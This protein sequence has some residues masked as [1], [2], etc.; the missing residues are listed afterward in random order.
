MGG[1]ELLDVLN[2]PNTGQM[3]NLPLGAVVEG[4]VLI[5][6]DRIDP[7]TYG[8]VPAPLQAMLAP[9]AMRQE[10]ICQ[11]CINRDEELALEAL[12]ADPLINDYHDAREMWRELLAANETYTPTFD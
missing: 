9:A 11:A 8:T 3:S 2:R 1:P 12:L 4:Q 7:V 6:K 10:M 5:T